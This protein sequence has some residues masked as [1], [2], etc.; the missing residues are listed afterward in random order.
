MEAYFLLHKKWSINVSYICLSFRENFPSRSTQ[1]K[2]ALMIWLYYKEDMG[3]KRIICILH[4]IRFKTLFVFWQLLFISI[5][6]YIS[7]RK[8]YT[9]KSSW[10]CVLFFC[11]EHGNSSKYCLILTLRSKACMHNIQLL[12]SNFRQVLVVHFISSYAQ[13]QSLFLWRTNVGRYSYMLR[14]LHSLKGHCLGGKCL[15]RI[16]IKVKVIKISKFIIL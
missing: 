1:I 14:T 11:V 16:S 6:L 15:S 4:F 10:N 8:W 12:I 2:F 3:A 13:I 9:R 5:F 7:I